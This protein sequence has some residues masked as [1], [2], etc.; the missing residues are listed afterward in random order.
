MKKYKKLRDFF[1]KHNINKEVNFDNW[2]DK[3]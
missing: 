2:K 1:I 3:D